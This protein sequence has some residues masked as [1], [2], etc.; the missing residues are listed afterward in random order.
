MNLKNC[1]ILLFCLSISCLLIHAVRL[2]D[3]NEKE[4]K[5]K[6]KDAI[7]QVKQDEKKESAPKTIECVICMENIDTK[8]C[9]IQFTWCGH[10][11]HKSCLLEWTLKSN[12]C[13]ECESVD[14]ISENIPEESLSKLFSSNNESN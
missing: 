8:G 14:P 7:I 11:Y 1:V 9:D 5:D 4:L 10:L 6:E 12:T 2:K 3:L 13:P